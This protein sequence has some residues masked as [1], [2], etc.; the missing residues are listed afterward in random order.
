MTEQTELVR[1]AL[2]AQ[3]RGR[4][5]GL[6]VTGQAAAASFDNVRDGGRFLGRPAL[7][8]DQA[9]VRRDALMDGRGWLEQPL[10]VARL[11]GIRAAHAVGNLNQTRDALVT[12][13]AR[14]GR[15]ARVRGGD[16][17][18][19]SLAVAL[20]AVHRRIHAVRARR[21]ADQPRAGRRF[22]AAWRVA[23]GALGPIVRFVG[24]LVTGR[25]VIE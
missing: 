1:P 17:F 10:A 5:F 4:Q 24:R 14:R 3:R 8:A 18:G 6:A 9:R 2:V 15:N 13:S 7:V 25:A 20:Q 19:F 11:A 12:G 21:R 22:P 23:R 16:R